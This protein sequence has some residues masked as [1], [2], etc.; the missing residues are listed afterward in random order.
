MKTGAFAGAVL[1]LCIAAPAAAQMAVGGGLYAVKVTTLRDIPFRTV[2][3]Q[4]YDYSCGSAALATLLSHHYGVRVTEA[5]VFE[6]M[7]AKGD[8]E[9][10]RKVGFSLLDMKRHLATRGMTADGYR[11]TLKQLEAAKAPALAVI[12]VGSYRHFVVIKGVR[13]GEVLVGDP[14]LGLKTYSEAEF[15]KV[16]N[17][18]VFAV[19]TAPGYQQAAYNREEEWR[20][21]AVAPLG[22][23]LGESSLGAFTRELPPVYQVTNPIVIAGSLR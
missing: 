23:P 1:A 4:Q 11:A 13:G 18:I 10:I 21:W 20:P 3:R 5:E 19:H 9:K 14:A 12:S 16:W 15:A 8:Q 6:A 2:V 17:G 7:Y 22:R